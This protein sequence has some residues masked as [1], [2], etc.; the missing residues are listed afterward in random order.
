MYC[1]VPSCRGPFYL[2]PVNTSNAKSQKKSTLFTIMPPE[3][4]NKIFDLVCTHYKDN[5]EPISERQSYHRSHFHHYQNRKFSTA[6]LR[7]CKRVYEETKHLPRQSYE[8]VFWMERK[9]GRNLADWMSELSSVQ[10]YASQIWLEGNGIG[11]LYLLNF[12]QR[13]QH[14]KISMRSLEWQ[15]TVRHEPKPMQPDPYGFNSMGPELQKSWLLRTFELEV[16]TVASRKAELDAAVEQLEDWSMPVG[17]GQKT[18]KLNQEKTLRTGWI[19]PEDCEYFF[20]VSERISC[21]TFALSFLFHLLVSFLYNVPDTS[22]NS[23]ND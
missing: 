6:I 13:L 9:E 4:R 5:K 3:L 10:I 23:Y 11:I 2:A 14:V 18:L 22:C 20:S 7:T 17:P 12:C 1:V 21:W 16:E 19:G 8:G 15:P